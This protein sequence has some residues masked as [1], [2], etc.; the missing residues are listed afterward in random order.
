[1]QLQIPRR[2]MATFFFFF[3]ELCLQFSVEFC[4]GYHFIIKSLSITVNY[5]IASQTVFVGHGKVGYLVEIAPILQTLASTYQMLV[6]GWK[7]FCEYFTWLTYIQYSAGL[8]ARGPIYTA[9]VP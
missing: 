2:G 5:F 9:S 1:M 7:Y 3:S 4:K 8:R 6:R